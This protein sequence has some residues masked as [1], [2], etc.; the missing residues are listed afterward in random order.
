MN[1]GQLIEQLQKLQATHGDG[2]V[3][4]VDGPGRWVYAVIGT[5][6]DRYDSDEGDVIEIIMDGVAL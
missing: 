3:Y 2:R 6:W 5:D 1:V 4:V